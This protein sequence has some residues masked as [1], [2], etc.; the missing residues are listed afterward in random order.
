LA[1]SEDN[2]IV[3]FLDRHDAGRQLAA[4]LAAFAPAHPVIVALPRGG[5]PIA[6]EVARAL[7]APLDILA[8]R[9]LGAPGNP[10]LA[11]GAVAEDGTGVLDQRSAGRLGMTQATLDD[12]LERE[13]R[14]LRRRV[15]RYRDG[16]PAVA[17]SGRSAIVVDDGLA[18]GLT[19]L[20]AV[21][22]LRKR[23]AREVVVAVP[24]GSREAVA[25]LAREAD[26]VV[27]LEIPP[28]LF[29]VGMWY[30]NFAPVSDEQ[31]E[32][33]LARAGAEQRQIDT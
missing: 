17:V 20:A 22:A 25:M 26:R 23:G 32:A 18:T 11:V 31:V 8:V 30:R 16:R 14:E 7:R 9:K 24:I 19:D 15:E 21:R 28:R 3:E 2:P 27:C 13:S 5:V 6:F 12:T 10:E 1:S 33:L 4:E 29:G